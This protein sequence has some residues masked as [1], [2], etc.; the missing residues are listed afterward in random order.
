MQQLCTV[1]QRMLEGVMVYCMWHTVLALCAP[2][3]A[4]CMATHKQA[5]EVSCMLA[6][7]LTIQSDTAPVS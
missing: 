5:T 6:C 1:H 3:A 4:T 2:R 7:N